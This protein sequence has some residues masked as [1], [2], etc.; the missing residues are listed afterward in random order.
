MTERTKLLLAVLLGLLLALG[1]LA[2]WSIH[3]TRQAHADH[4]RDNPER[5]LARLVDGA[6]AYYADEHVT[7]AGD[8][9]PAQFPASA[10]LTPTASP[11]AQG[12]VRYPPEAG[13]WDHAT[14]QAL[15]FAVDDPHPYR[16][17]FVAGPTGFTARA[18]GDL[19]CDG[20]LSTFERIGTVDAAGEIHVLSFRNNEVE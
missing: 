3:R 18:L 20:A 9:L 8:V 14:W 1:G 10:P 16:Y 2:A 7:A 5:R 4:I 13:L 6:R 11:C 15:R 19:D 12:A 17:E